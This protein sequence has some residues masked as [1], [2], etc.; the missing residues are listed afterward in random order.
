M[1]I[2]NKHL[3]FFER[4]KLKRKTK[5]DDSAEQNLI[6]GDTVIGDL[7]SQNMILLPIPIDPHRR[8]GPITEKFLHLSSK[9]L[10]YNFR[11]DRPNDN[12]S[13]SNNITKS[14]YWYPKDSRFH[15]YGNNITF[16]RNRSIFDNVKSRTYWVST[17]FFGGQCTVLFSRRP[18][19]SSKNDARGPT[20]S[21]KTRHM[22]NRYHGA[23]RQ[24]DCR[25]ETFPWCD[26]QGKTIIRRDVKNVVIPF[27]I[28]LS[29]FFVS[30]LF[31]S[32]FRGFD[33]TL[34]SARIV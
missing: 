25:F 18:T 4:N 6:H 29:I 22:Y 2:A 23:R 21:T 7:L 27:I 8:W 16:Q 15:Y 30:F 9:P 31:D 14:Y 20:L 33:A 17:T 11:S 5:R 24:F 10:Q 19:R 32:A 3:Q 28:F 12:V 13:A 1:A 34:A 26:L